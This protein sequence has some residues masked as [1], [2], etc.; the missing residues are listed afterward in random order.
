MEILVQK[1]QALSC[2][3]NKG[4]GEIIRTFLIIC[5]IDKGMEICAK[6]WS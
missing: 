6:K 2:L 1:E 3:A 5:Q 4:S